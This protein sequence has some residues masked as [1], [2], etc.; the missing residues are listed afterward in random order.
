MSSRLRHL[1]IDC[2]EVS[3]EECSIDMGYANSS[4]LRKAISGHCF[5]DPEKLSALSKIKNHDDSSPNIHWLI[6][7]E[8]QA[9]IRRGLDGNVKHSD[10]YRKLEALSPDKRAA[11]ATLLG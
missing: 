11:L 5:V 3:I 4:V 1:V 2:L 8:G 6:T 10:L 7:G 9:L